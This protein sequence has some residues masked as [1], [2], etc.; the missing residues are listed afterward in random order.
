MG[1]KSARWSGGLSL[2]V[3]V[4]MGSA[5]KCIRSRQSI[6]VAEDMFA[7]LIEY[8]FVEYVL[9]DE[10]DLISLCLPMFA[11][12]TAVKLHRTRKPRVHDKAMSNS[13]MMRCSRAQM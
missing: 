1:T 8:S 9:D 5:E 11:A 10:R 6:Y 3:M 7:V 12:Q 13:K 2:I 4:S